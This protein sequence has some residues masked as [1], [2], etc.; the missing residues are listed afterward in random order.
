MSKRVII[1][2]NGPTHAVEIPENTWH[3]LIANE[4]NTVLMEVKPG[5]Y[6]PLAIEDFAPWAPE[7]GAPGTADFVSKFR[8]AAHGQSCANR[9]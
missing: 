5:P 3:T 9:E 1:S 8:H 7:E 2:G 6:L 4:E